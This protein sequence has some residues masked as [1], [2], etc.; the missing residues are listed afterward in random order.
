MI[1]A[2]GNYGL[3]TYRTLEAELPE[4]LEFIRAQEHL[5]WQLQVLESS[6]DPSA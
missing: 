2:P 5:S 4:A 3:M 1:C 6:R